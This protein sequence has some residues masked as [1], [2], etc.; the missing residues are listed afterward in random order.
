MILFTTKNKNVITY[1]NGDGSDIVYGF[2]DDD[3][4]KIT[5]GSYSTSVSGD[6][7]IVIVGDN[8]ITLKYA[9][10]KNISIA[11]SKGKVENK[12]FAS[13]EF[14]EDETNFSELDMIVEKDFE[15]SDIQAETTKIISP[16]K[17]TTPNFILSPAR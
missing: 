9:T 1:A 8:S 11:N 17:S 12:A 13:S 7:V 10:N 5:S 2:N 16:S 3:T 6:D 15:L 14:S 4:L